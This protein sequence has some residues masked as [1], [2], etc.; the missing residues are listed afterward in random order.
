MDSLEERRAA[1]EEA[2]GAPV[3]TPVSSEADGDTALPEGG[4]MEIETGTENSE[5]GEDVKQTGESSDPEGVEGSETGE[6]GGPQLPN[7][8]KPFRT[9]GTAKEWRQA[10]GAEVERAIGKRLEKERRKLES[11]DAS[12]R[13]KLAA[14]L[15]VTPERAEAAFEAL[16]QQY[17]LDDSLTRMQTAS[18][19]GERETALA[20]KLAQYEEREETAK[21]E[22]LQIQV[23]QFW[24][25]VAAQ[26]EGLQKRFPTLNVDAVYQSENLRNFLWEAY[27]IDPANAAA[28]LVKR[29]GLMEVKAAPKPAPKTREAAPPDGARTQART[30]AS[31]A[32]GKTLSL[33]ERRAALEA[34]LNGL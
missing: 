30:D 20:D 18:A 4:G 26:F 12:L 14:A 5:P 27:R 24:A 8:V 15:N 28:L 11:A 3:D 25:D 17:D 34:R 33:A 6:T 22:A 2:L 9:F 10:V 32:A 21:E 1:F 31:A 13:G 19:A 16:L 23:D 29:L 7:E